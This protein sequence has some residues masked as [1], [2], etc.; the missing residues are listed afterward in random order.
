MDNTVYKLPESAFWILRRFM[1]KEKA[2]YLRA[3]FEE[4]YNRTAAEKGK[5]PSPVWLWYQFLN[6][7][8]PILMH[9]LFLSMA[10]LKNM[11]KITFRNMRKQKIYS[12]INIIGLVV[13]MVCC[14]LIL[15]WIQDELSYD[16]FHEKADRIVRVT[17]LWE[18]ADGAV[19]LHLGQV[20]PPIGPLLENDFP[21]VERAVRILQVDECLLECGNRCFKENMF[22]FADEDFFDLF[23]FE[24]IQGDPQ[25]A[26]RDPFTMVITDEMARKYFGSDEALGKTI[27]FERLG[28]QADYQITGIIRKMPRNSH[29]HADFL[30]SFRTYEMVV[31]ASAMQNW[32]NNDCATYLLISQS[33]DIRHL[34]GQLDDFIK[35]HYAL[36][37]SERTRLSLQRLT[38]IHLHSHLDSEIEPNGNMADV[39]IFSIVAFFVLLIACINFMNLATARSMN[40]AKEVGIRKVMGAS[41]NQLIR[42]FLVESVVMAAMALVL[43][44]L[45]VHLF[46][47]SF[48]RL[49]VKELSFNLIQNGN[50]LLALLGIG[51]FVGIISGSYPAFFLSSFTPVRVLRGSHGFGRKS[52]SLRTCLVIFQFSISIFLIASVGIVNRQLRYMHDKKLGFD[53]E[54]VLVLPSDPAITGQLEA[55]KERLLRHA[56][57]VSVSASKQ[58]PSDRL[59]DFAPAQVLGGDREGPVEF[60][61]AQLRVDHDYIPTF[62]IEMAAGRNFSKSISTDITQA[63]ILN[64]TAVR[65]IGWSSPQQAIDQEFNYGILRGRIIGVVK[66][67]HFESF[68]QQIAPILLLLSRSSL[69]QI[70]VRIRPDDIPSTLAFLEQQWREYRPGFPFYYFFIDDRFDQLYRSEEKLNQVF[71]LFAFL[72]IFVACLGLFGLASFT[73]EQRMREIGIR[74]TLGATVPRVVALLVSTFLKWVLIANVVALPFTWLMMHRWLEG[75]AYRV[76]I[77]WVVFVQSAV[78]AVVIALITV[79]VQSVRAAMANPIDSLNYE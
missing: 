43:A 28:Q 48:N 46:L 33:A 78:L 76:G 35:R 36:S 79:S 41:R 62:G 13:G 21:E 34:E 5:T 55:F 58:V 18:N 29:F 42:Q 44:V 32:E 59:L 39:I 6:T 72:A 20:A 17:R 53:K 1:E 38:D 61:L 69:D 57:I 60:M 3:D 50:I 65:S 40:R 63:F 77:G 30:S 8:M 2:E 15:L 56:N 14:L 49:I 31:G 37:E 26:L 54:Q 45:L 27:R 16:R 10:M 11:L 51:V 23:T 19:S 67:F 7:L 74:K 4:V 47:P 73:A 52:V 75:F 70:S 25:L 22:F 66:D 24:M 9:R 68:H 12:S 64:E 71:G